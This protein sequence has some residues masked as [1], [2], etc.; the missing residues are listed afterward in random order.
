VARVGFQWLH[1]LLGMVSSFLRAAQLASLLAQQLRVTSALQYQV[2]HYQEGY[3]ELLIYSIEE[4]RIKRSGQCNL[5]NSIYSPP[6]V[7]QAKR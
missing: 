4:E 1:I 7:L 2:L 6:F 3:L 5:T